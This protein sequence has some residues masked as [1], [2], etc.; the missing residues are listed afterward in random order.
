[1]DFR[2]L[3]L[4]RWPPRPAADSETEAAEPLR[5]LQ[6]D[7]N[8]AFE[9]FWRSFPAPSFRANWGMT[10]QSTEPRIDL[11]ETDREIE[12]TAE[13]PGLEERDIEVSLSEDCVTIKAEKFAGRDRQGGGYRI[14]ERLYG[15]VRRT[16]PLPAAVD[17][18]AVKASYKNGVLT[19]SIPKIAEPEKDIRHIPVNKS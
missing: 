5:A 1:M 17:Q 13:M 14:N 7:I 12:L 4:W 19:I 3:M 16:I 2:D 15:P 6:A 9:S 8:R 11:I 10:L 18:E